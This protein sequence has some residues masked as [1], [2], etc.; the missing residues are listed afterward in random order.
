MDNILGLLK[1]KIM[2]A[3]FII[4]GCDN[5]AKKKSLRFI[6]WKAE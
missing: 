5:I 2:A 6:L 4:F 1:D 3:A